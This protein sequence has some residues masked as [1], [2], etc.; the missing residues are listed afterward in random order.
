VVALHFYSTRQCSH[1]K[2]CTSYSNS[3]RLSVCLFICLSV[4]HT[5]VFCQN[6]CT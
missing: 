5:P 2:H 6:D 1:C 3:V 4:C